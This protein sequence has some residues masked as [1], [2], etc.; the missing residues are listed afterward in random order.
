MTHRNSGTPPGR[1]GRLGEGRFIGRQIEGAQYFVQLLEGMGVNQV[2][3]DLH[4]PLPRYQGIIPRELFD[5]R[6]IVQVDFLAEPVEPVLPYAALRNG[7]IVPGAVG[8][9]LPEV[10]QADHHVAV[11]GPAYVVIY[12][13]AEDTKAHPDQP[14]DQ[15]GAEAFFLEVD[16]HG[17]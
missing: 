7:Q 14:Q 9:V 17:V 6:D 4:I 12:F 8:P 13:Q 15:V 3:I 2:R 10:Q 16:L 1:S 5:P 11:V